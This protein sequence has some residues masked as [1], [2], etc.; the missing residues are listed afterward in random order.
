MNDRLTVKQTAHLMNAGEQ[1]IR[2][3][4]QQNRLPF[5]YAVQTSTKWTY[6]ISK[7]KFMEYTGIKIPDGNEKAHQETDIS[8]VLKQK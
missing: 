3:G 2:R 1:F 6:F 5:G 4:L 8:D 7:S